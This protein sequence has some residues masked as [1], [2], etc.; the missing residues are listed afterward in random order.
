MLQGDLIYALAGIRHVCL[1]YKSTATIYLRLGATTFVHEGWDH[2]L[3]GVMLNQKSLEMLKPLLLSQKWCIAVEEWTD[4][5]FIVDLDKSREFHTELNLP[6][7]HIARW[8]FY[9]HPDLACDLSVPWLDVD[10]AEEIPDDAIVVNRTFRYLNE[11]YI[12]YSILK[13]FESRL[14][15]A[16]LPEEH[17]RFCLQNSLQCRILVVSD[18][19]QLARVIRSAKLFIGNQSFCY[20]LAEAMKVPRILEV[21]KN[22]PNVI[23]EGKNGFDFHFQSGLEFYLNKLA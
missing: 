23:P 7:G 21:W 22:A 18:Y 11:N 4:Q 1:Q 5:P 3:K 12:D 2:P 8:Y 6:F 13:K 9:T 20:A 19:L 17:E 15:F 10:P 14:I 16:G